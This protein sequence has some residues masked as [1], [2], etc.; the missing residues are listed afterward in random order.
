MP[1][2]LET[3]KNPLAL[4]SIEEMAD[5]LKIGRSVAY[6]MVRRSQVPIVTVGRRMAV[7][8]ETVEA[9]RRQRESEAM[10]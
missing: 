3:N 1:D 7:L 4:F 8:P 9:L 10:A 5:T 2:F 6:R